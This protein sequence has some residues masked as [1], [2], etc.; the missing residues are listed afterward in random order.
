MENQD[1]KS[2]L[3]TISNLEDRLIKM[4]SKEAYL[5]KKIDYLVKQQVD[6]EEANK[7]LT[8]EIKALKEENKKMR[9]D[10]I[11]VPAKGKVG[12]TETTG[13]GEL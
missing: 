3:A 11:K 9:E 13:L 6:S 5:E 12:I 7:Q 8:I 10:F 1:I 2:I 4:E